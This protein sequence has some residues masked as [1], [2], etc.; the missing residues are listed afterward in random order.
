MGH[1]IFFVEWPI[2]AKLSFVV[3]IT[4]AGLV[5][6]H[7]ILK[8]RKLTKA[9]TGDIERAE[10][11]ERIR[12]SDEI[13]FGAKAMLEDPEIEGVWNSRAS[14]PLQSP[15]LAPRNFSPSRMSFNLLSRS[16]R[17]S[18]ISSSPSLSGQTPDTSPGCRNST[19]R[20]ES[21]SQS[22]SDTAG[23]SIS[24]ALPSKSYSRDH[25][26]QQQVPK[27]HSE[28]TIVPRRRSVTIRSA[29]RPDNFVTKSLPVDD[30]PL[31][32]IGDERR[33]TRV[34]TDPM[35]ETP[36]HARHEQSQRASG[37][38][39]PGTQS[40]ERT[41]TTKKA[42]D[43]M[44]AHRKFHAAES[45]QLRPR[46]R[47]SEHRSLGHKHSTSE[48]GIITE[49]EN[50]RAVSWPITS[51]EVLVNFNATQKVQTQTSPHVVP[52]RAFVEMHPPPKSPLRSPPSAW[53]EKTQG[54]L[55]E[56]L[57]AAQAPRKRVVIRNS[58]T[59]DEIPKKQLYVVSNRE[60]YKSEQESAS[61]LGDQSHRV[62]HGFEVLP[63]GKLEEPSLVKEFGYLKEA[64]QETSND[65]K[66]RKLQ[67]RNRSSSRERP[68]L[69]D[70]TRQIMV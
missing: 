3:I 67:R 59:T 38:V 65:S 25:P 51:G 35:P 4:L 64:L 53:T 12:S 40:M 66:P 63:V 49:Q 60:P 7:K 45:G 33:R 10:V 2:W 61:W 11:R 27:S 54:L 1:F 15:I 5:K 17:N 48:N 28:G 16:R 42:L 56:K 26:W 34:S 50:T 6:L 58:N 37:P 8:V 46:T 24:T 19:S 57:E 14:T 21:C 18:S 41:P 30:E 43:R 13:P 39:H 31:V 69:V 9:Q 70:G 36:T 68:G 44:E 20:K 47:S 55:E 23:T 52:F 32:I 29:L 62:S 22:D